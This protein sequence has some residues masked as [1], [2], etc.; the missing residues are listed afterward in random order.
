MRWA[1]SN[2]MSSYITRKRSSLLVINRISSINEWNSL[3]TPSSTRVYRSALS[4]RRYLIM[5]IV[6]FQVV[7]HWSTLSEPVKPTVLLIQRHMSSKRLKHIRVSKPFLG[8]PLQRL[9]NYLMP[10]KYSSHQRL[11]NRIVNGWALIQDVISSAILST[12]MPTYCNDDS[13]T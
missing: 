6:E 2:W 5:N 10:D 3:N 13:I 7:F 12:T 11:R 1:N 8:Q 9:L 4:Q